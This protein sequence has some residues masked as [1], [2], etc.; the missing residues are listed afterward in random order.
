MAYLLGNTKILFEPYTDVRA[1]ELT[2]Y[3]TTINA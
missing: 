2:N 3:F 1:N